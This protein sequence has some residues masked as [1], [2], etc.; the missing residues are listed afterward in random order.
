MVRVLRVVA[1]IEAC[2]YLVL[3]GTLALR[4]VAGGP[5]VSDVIGPVHGLV[6]LTYAVVVVLAREDAGWSGRRTLT[7]A[8]AA[9]VPLGGFYVARALADGAGRRGTGET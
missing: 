4:L 1:P 2:T 9:A 6:F 8:G 3:L 5:D 7:I